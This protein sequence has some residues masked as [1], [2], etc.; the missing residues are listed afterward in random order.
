VFR[1]V[2]ISVAFPSC[3]AVLV[4]CWWKH[5]RICFLPWNIS[6]MYPLN[7]LYLRN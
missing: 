3:M 6:F 5:W 7:N 4:W 2:Q 1:A